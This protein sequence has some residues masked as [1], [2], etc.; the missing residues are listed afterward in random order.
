MTRNLEIDQFYSEQCN[1]ILV[2]LFC[3]YH[4]TRQ[5]AFSSLAH[6]FWWLAQ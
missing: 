4:S 2:L 5:P 3:I 1:V 6:Y